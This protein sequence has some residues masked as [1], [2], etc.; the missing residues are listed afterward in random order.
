[1]KWSAIGPLTKGGVGV[2]K[3][4]KQS[5][6]A[7]VINYVTHLGTVVYQRSEDEEYM[8]LANQVK[9]REVLDV[10]DEKEF[11]QLWGDPDTYLNSFLTAHLNLVKF[12]P[13]AEITEFG[14][15]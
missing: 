8:Y 5:G 6:Y 9:I 12:V 4:L 15:K 1:M 3:F 14:K 11:L 2:V 7:Y 13:G 10:K